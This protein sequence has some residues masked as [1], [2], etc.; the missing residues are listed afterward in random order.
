MTSIAYRQSGRS[1]SS[2]RSGSGIVAQISSLAARLADQWQQ[3]RNARE[4]ESMPLD[5]RKDFGWPATDIGADRK[6]MQ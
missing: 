4:I 6:D 1:Q 5:M 3:A 2:L